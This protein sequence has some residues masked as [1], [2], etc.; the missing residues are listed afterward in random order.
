MG[1]WRGQFHT[2][3]FLWWLLKISS[4]CHKILTSY[5]N[6]WIMSTILPESNFYDHGLSPLPIENSYSNLILGINSLHVNQFSKFMLPIL[7]QIECQI[8]FENILPFSKE[9]INNRRKV[10]LRSQNQDINPSL[11]CCQNWKFMIMGYLPWQCK[12][13]VQNYLWTYNLFSLF[14]LPIFK[15]FA[16]HITTN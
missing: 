14:F 5:Q 15:I 10:I 4:K 8:L 6:F 7:R 2:E 9:S 16:S 11:Q 3:L 1:L 13:P 12:I